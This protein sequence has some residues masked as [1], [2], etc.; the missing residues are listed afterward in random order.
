MNF[1]RVGAPMLGF[2]VCGQYALTMVVQAKNEKRDA[3][4]KI[5]PNTPME[6]LKPAISYLPDRKSRNETD[7]QILE[8]QYARMQRKMQS[9]GGWNQDKFEP[10]R[11]ERRE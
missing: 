7:Q 10:K 9:K 3:K 11:V 1:M 6:L 4:T 8:E 5:D 2:M